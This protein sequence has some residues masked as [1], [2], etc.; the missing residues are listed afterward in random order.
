M[1]LLS[2]KT[3]SISLVVVL[4][5]C[6]FSMGPKAP[7]DIKIY[8]FNS[9]AKW[10]RSEWCAGKSGFVRAQAKQVIAP[11]DANGFIG[12]TPEDFSRVLEACPKG[13]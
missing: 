2:L 10:C 3:L 7:K 6:A 9:D 12:M 5:N 1:T 13:Q 4:S 8:E 11:K